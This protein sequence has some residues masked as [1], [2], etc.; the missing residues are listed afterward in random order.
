MLWAYNCPGI[1]GEHLKLNTFI[2]EATESG[3]AGRRKR[4][5]GG[6]RPAQRTVVSPGVMPWHARKDS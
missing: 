5:G 1:K 3:G 6:G 4:V 2:K